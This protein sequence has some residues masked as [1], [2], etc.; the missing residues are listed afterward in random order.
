MMWRG[1]SF[2]AVLLVI[3]PPGLH[4]NATQVRE[5]LD[6]LVTAIL[7][8]QETCSQ[9]CADNLIKLD[10]GYFLAF[11]ITPGIQSSAY[12]KFMADGNS[13]DTDCLV[14]QNVPEGCKTTD[15]RLSCDRHYRSRILDLWDRLPI[16]RV[17]VG[18]YKDNVEQRFFEFNGNSS[19][20]DNWF[21]QSRLINNS[22]TDLSATQATPNFF[23]IVGDQAFGRPFF[24]NNNYGGC[25][26]DAGW[27]MVSDKADPPCPWEKRNTTNSYPVIFFSSANAKSI[28]SITNAIADT[29]VI[30]VKLGNTQ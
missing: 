28:Y 18:V 27:L 25:D 9:S 12:E 7:E 10:N 11:R 5:I 14:F 20:F 29:L 24:I 8:N 2:L 21:S 30:S 23:S 16:A 3:I 6:K 17:R 13:D 4:A 26:N 19:N 1:L 22:Y 15:G